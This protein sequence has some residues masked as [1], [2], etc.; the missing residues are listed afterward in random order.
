MTQAAMERRWR[1]LVVATHPVQYAVHLFRLMAQ[2][3]EIDF[4]V[5]YCTMRGAEAAHDSEFGATVQWDI[6]LLDGYRWIHVPNRGSGKDSFFGLRNPGLRKLIREGNFDAINCHVSYLRASFWIAFFA[7]RAGGAGFLF[8]TDATSLTS[9]DGRSWKATVKRWLWPRLFRLA[10]QVAMPSAAGVALMK[11]LGIPEERISLTPFVVDNDW[12]IA[13][14]KNSDRAVTRATWSVTNTQRVV[15]FCAKLQNWKRPLDLLRA[16]ASAN[17]PDSV[18]V[19]AGEGP[20][21][22]EI[23]AEAAALGIAQGVRMLGFVNQ[24]QLPAVYAAADLFVMPSEYDPCPVVVCEAMV[25]GLPVILSDQ[26]RGRFDLVKPGCTGEIFP[27]GDVPALTA[28]LRTLL[29]DS[30]TLA[31]FSNNA[32][33]RMTTWSPHENITATVE[34]VKLAAQHRKPPPGMPHP[35]GHSAIS[36]PT[37]GKP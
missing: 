4:T 23:V 7:A 36:A 6:P 27:C 1:V 9:R 2:H 37:A 14:A 5:A 15:L 28:A 10:D 35:E 34:A 22:E 16:F 8:G 26:I 32:C 3:P 12:W 17:L 11:S 25:C 21:R 13:Q 31:S 24:S 33:A 20:Q 29:S 30:G 18:L 19:F